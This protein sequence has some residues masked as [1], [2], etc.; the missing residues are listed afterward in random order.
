MWGNLLH[1]VRTGES[2]C[3]R[4]YAK[5]FYDYLAQ[6]PVVGVPFNRYMTKT[7]EQHTTAILDCYDFSQLRTLVDVGGGEGI[8]LAAIL[9]AYPTTQGILFD[10][11]KVVR[12]AISLDLVGLAERCKLVGG[13]MQQ[14]APCGGDLYLIKWMLMDR[15]D[16]EAINVLRNCKE[17]MTD[18]AKILVVELVMPSDGKPSLNKI[19]DL[20]MM[21]LFGRGRIRTREELSSL[22]GLG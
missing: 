8:T 16:E 5:R 4:V 19:M 14:S 3:E 1:C 13:D 10:L 21:L 11:P 22:R 6:Y 9:K 20:Q 15:S 12:T 7:S 2:A 18:D 17:A